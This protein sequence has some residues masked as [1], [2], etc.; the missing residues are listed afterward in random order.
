MAV[1]QHPTSLTALPT[2]LAIEIT[3][4]LAVTLE[5]P[6]YDLCNLQATCSSMRRIYGNPTISRCLS[7]VQFICGM[8]WDDSV[9]YE[10]PLASLTQLGNLEACFFTGIQTLFMENHSPLAMPR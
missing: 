3:S 6:M 7:L 5:Q 9:N 2:D 1:R 10:T 8:T 4:H